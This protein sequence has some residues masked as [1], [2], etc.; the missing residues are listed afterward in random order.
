MALAA[1]MRVAQIAGALEWVL[2]QCVEHA[3]ARQQFGRSL[4]QFQVIQHAL[5]LLAE[6]SSAV[7]CAARAASRAVDLGDARFEIAAAQLRASQAIGT[8]TAIAHQVHG[9]IGCTQEHALQRAT[10]RLWAWRTEFGSERDWAVKLGRSIAA[11]GARRLWPTLTERGDRR[12]AA[13]EDAR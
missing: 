5:A 8:A 10:R 2:Q 1:L 9:A 11:A 3:A 13:D 4:S 6:E 7:S 12:S